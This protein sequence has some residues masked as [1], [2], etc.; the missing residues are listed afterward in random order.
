MEYKKLINIIENKEAKVVVVGL[1]YVG[2]PMAAI[3]AS[4]GYF[5]TGIDINHDI[6]N[7]VNNKKSPINEPGL[8]EIVYKGVE[9]GRLRATVEASEIRNSN[10][11]LIIVQ[12][13]VD[14]NKE[15]CLEAL[16]SATKAVAE[17]LSEGTLVVVESTIPPGTMRNKILPVLA[18]SGLKVGKDFFLANSPERAIPTRTLEEIQI[19]SR[20]V[21]GIDERS[22]ELAGVFYENITSGDV[23]KDAVEIVEVVKLIENTFRDV[24]IALANDV[25]LLCE[26]LGIDAIKAINLANKHPRVNFHMPGVGVGGHCIPKDPYFLIKEAEKHGVNLSVIKASRE[27]NSNMPFHV[28]EKLKSALK[29]QGKDIKEST[30]AVLGIAY[31]GNVDDVRETPAEPIIKTLMKSGVDVFSHDPYVSQDFG[32]KFSNEIKTVVKNADALVIVTDHDEY[33]K[34]DFGDLRL[35]MKDKAIILDGRRILN[36]EDIKRLGFIYYGIGC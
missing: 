36:P 18:S 16:M 20:V 34:L 30:V 25:A 26:A 2:L 19:N 35:L 28:L 17:N 5:T 27:R 1:G 4:R 12:T 32:G 7:K 29:K 31:K 33:K 14:E 11:V 23:Y 9:A 8:E 15:P 3:V 13:P 24:N 6:V 22:A 21:G 10:V